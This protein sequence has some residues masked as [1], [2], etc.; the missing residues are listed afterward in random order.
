VKSALALPPLTVPWTGMP[1]IV[2]P[3]L[4]VKVTVPSLTETL[5]SLLSATAARSV[6]V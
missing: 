6:T 5:G 2:L 1:I 3:F 4:T